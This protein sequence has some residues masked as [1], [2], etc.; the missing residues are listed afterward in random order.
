MMQFNAKRRA[1]LKSAAVAS[2]GLAL[3]TLIASRGRAQGGTEAINFQLPFLFG[4]TETGLIVADKLGYFEEEKLA[5]NIMPGGPSMDGIA[6]VAS[7]QADLGATSSSPNLM[8]AVSKKIPIKAFMAQLQEH[9]YIFVSRADKP[10]RTPQ[11]MIGKRIGVNQTGVILVNA[12]LKVN[13]ID[14]SQVEIVTIGGDLTPLLTGQVDV[15]TAWETSVAQLSKLGDIVTMRLWDSG[16]QLYANVTYGN[17]ATLTKRPD[18]VAAFVRALGRGWDYVYGNEE[19]AVEMLIAT[20][21][22][23]VAANELKVMPILKKYMFNANTEKDGWATFDPAVWQKQ[24]NL[25]DELGQFGA[26][27]PA[28][29]D[30][31]TTQILDATKDARPKQP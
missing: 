10:V 29:N 20:A 2:V 28:I 12:V 11:D 31:I 5:I 23:T 30:I 16:V 13:N 22:G 18:A 26:G 1:L 25:Y 19:K 27:K 6:I 9:P 7:G 21:T 15:V 3:P 17:V 4:S 14:P 8:L 24:I